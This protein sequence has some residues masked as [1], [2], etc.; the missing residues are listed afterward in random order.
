MIEDYWLKFS[1]DEVIA[2]LDPR[3]IIREKGPADMSEA[4]L[5]D[6][7]VSFK[8]AVRRQIDKWGNLCVRYNLDKSTPCSPTVYGR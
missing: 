1:I 2:T 8:D 3:D 6:L 5:N 7:V 4:L